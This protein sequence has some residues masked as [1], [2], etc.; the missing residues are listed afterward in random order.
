MKIT[1]LH[2]DGSFYP[3]A[4]EAAICCFLAYVEIHTLHRLLPQSTTKSLQIQILI[5][6]FH[7]KG[8]LPVPSIAVHPG[9]AE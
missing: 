9:S 6:T 5:Q 1:G 7:F 2:L 3:L 8:H 4:S